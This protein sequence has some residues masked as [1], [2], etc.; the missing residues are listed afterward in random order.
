MDQAH[1]IGHCGA[2]TEASVDLSLEEIGALNI[3]IDVAR[4]AYTQAEKRLQDALDTRK[5]FDQKAFTLF[6]AYITA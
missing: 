2:L 1:L 4:E 6:S 3:N 5:A